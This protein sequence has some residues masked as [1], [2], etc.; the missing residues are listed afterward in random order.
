MLASKDQD[1]MVAGS[2]KGL[3]REECEDAL[4]VLSS[5]DA[6]SQTATDDGRRIERVT[7]NGRSV[8][9]VVNHALY[10]S[11]GSAEERREQ[12]RKRVAKYRERQACNASVTQVTPSDQIRSNQIKDPPCSPP[13]EKPTK[14]PQRKRQAKVRPTS[15]APNAKHVELAQSNQLD[16]HSESAKF[17]DHHDAKG[18]K[19]V[20]WDAAFRTWLRNAVSFRPQSQHVQTPADT[21][22]AE[23]AALKR[24]ADSKAFLERERAK[25]LAEM[26]ARKSANSGPANTKVRNAAES[27]ASS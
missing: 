24:K 6:D 3:A 10:R 4:T 13:T 21:N 17:C 15:W 20:D 27:T 11:L 12:T 23:Q 16:L 2:T 18:S 8:W 9:R 25:A 1:G 22:R 14:K 26:K 19:F 7:V 5:P